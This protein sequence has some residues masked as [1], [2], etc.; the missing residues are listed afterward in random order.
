MR[1]YDSDSLRE[2]LGNELFNTENALEHTQV[3]DKYFM[4]LKLLRATLCN[5]ILLDRILSCMEDEINRSSN[6]RY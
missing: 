4:G 3:H 6:E 1:K 5:G 2:Y